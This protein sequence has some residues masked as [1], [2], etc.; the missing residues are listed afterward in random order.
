[1]ILNAATMSENGKKV[2][3]I[4]QESYDGPW[5]FHQIL[6]KAPFLHWQQLNGVLDG[7]R[8]RGIIKFSTSKTWSFTR[9]GLLYD[10]DSKDNIKFD[11]EKE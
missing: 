11:Y 3:K 6:A 8:R 1:M 2:L 7:L 4:L 10:P 5:T 9:E